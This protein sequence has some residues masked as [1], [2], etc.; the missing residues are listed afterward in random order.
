MSGKP[1]P[2]AGARLEE[3]VWNV[4]DLGMVGFR[5]KGFSLQAFFKWQ[6]TGDIREASTIH[7]FLVKLLP[8]CQ[9]CLTRWDVFS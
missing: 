7:Y 4:F 3:K 9:A 1:C 2:G 8:Q 6:K 5:S